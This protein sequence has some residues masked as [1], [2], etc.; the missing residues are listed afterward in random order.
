MRRGARA[1]DDGAATADQ[2]SRR[3]N[4]TGRTRGL[5]SHHAAT[6]LHTISLSIYLSIVVFLLTARFIQWSVTIPPMTI[7]SPV[8]CTLLLLL[9]TV[10]VS[11][12]SALPENFFQLMVNCLNVAFTKVPRLVQYQSVMLIQTTIVSTVF[13]N[14]APGPCSLSLGHTPHKCCHGRSVSH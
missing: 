11:R 4:V 3:T 1:A 5:G 8:H 13:N 12:R 6:Q 10:N 14:Y 2:S 7:Y 9:H